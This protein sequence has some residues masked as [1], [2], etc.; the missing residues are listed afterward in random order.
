MWGSAIS[1]QWGRDQRPGRKRIYCTLKLSESH[2]CQSFL[3]FWVPCFTVE[4][5]KLSIS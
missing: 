3:I 1:S 4:R 2:W 5:S